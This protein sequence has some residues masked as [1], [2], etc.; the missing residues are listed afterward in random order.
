MYGLH[1]FRLYNFSKCY[2][3]TIG[4]SVRC[5]YSIYDLLDT[6]D[7]LEKQI[8]KT[9]RLAVPTPRNQ[10]TASEISDINESSPRKSNTPNIDINPVVDEQ[11]E[12][13]KAKLAVSS[14]KH[15][16]FQINTKTF[17]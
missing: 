10:E 12:Q 3:S 1:W 9:R 4:S 14:L 17:V 13:L 5:S 7:A 11:L 8:N 15:H 16:Y 2:I 6:I